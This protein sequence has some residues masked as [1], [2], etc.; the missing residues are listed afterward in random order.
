MKGPVLQNQSCK[1]STTLGNLGISKRRSS[2]DNIVEA[3]GCEP[4]YNEY[5]QVKVFGEKG[6]LC[7]TP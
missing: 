5:L 2:I 4:D 7:D 3:R 6:V 1:T